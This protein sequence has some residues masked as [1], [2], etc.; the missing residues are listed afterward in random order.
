MRRLASW[1]AAF[2]LALA[3]AVPAVAHADVTPESLYTQAELD[4]MLAPIALYPDELLAQVLMAA[5][6]PLEV[7]QAARWSRANP[8]L[9]GEDAV[10]AVEDMD[11][12]PS[13]KSLVAFPQ[14]LAM[15]DEQLEWTERLGEAFLGDE[16]RAADSVQRLRRAAWEAGN[17][18]SSDEVAVTSDGGEILIAPSAP[19]VVYVPYYDPNVVYG[20]WWWPEAPPVYWAPWPGYVWVSPYFAWSIG[21]PV[22]IDFFYGGFDWRRHHVRV[23][24]RRPFYAHPDRD[25][26]SGDW[27]HDPD[28]RRG[29]PYR[30]P[31]LR[32]EYGVW[33]GGRRD[34]HS[35]F[36]PA[37]P[38]QAVQPQA[39]PR[40]SAP[41]ARPA[42]GVPSSRQSAPAAPFARPST[43]AA[44][45]ASPSL[46]P[47]TMPSYRAV[48]PAPEPRPQAFE[49]IGRGQDARSFSQRGQQSSG[50]RSP[51]A[52]APRASPMA[53]PV[54]QRS[55]P[56]APAARAPAPAPAA[57]APSAPSAPPR[58]APPGRGVERSSR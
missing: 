8:Q 46:S 6:Y 1:L 31:L 32:T 3:G 38:S 33:P 5:T 58:S 47:R 42:P 27:R 15:M 28:H 11:W 4:Q 44:P 45:S 19:E 39:A 24:D 53:R 2:L 54:P 56:S 36:F 49:G 22:G 14:V 29:V 9:G 41:L 26:R 50:A 17:L 35:G 20:T 40:A 21:I 43:P 57:R 18:R 25:W 30:N 34:A 16:S 23:H 7:V 51:A 10:R 55:A 37:Q 13:V 48:R 12:D 52:P